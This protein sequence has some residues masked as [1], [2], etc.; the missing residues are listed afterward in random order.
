MSWDIFA[1]DVPHE[2]K[3]VEVVPLD[4]KPKS[5]GTRSAVIVKI[6]EV[7]PTAD[8]SDPSWG[9][10]D[11]DGW[12]IEVSMGEDGE[13]DGFTLHVRGSDG[14]VAAVTSILDGLRIRAIDAQTGEFFVAGPTAIESFQAWHAWRERA[15]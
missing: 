5:L 7:F 6:K 14:A 1:M 10:I 2:F 15:G 9:L 3:S 11:G 8:F 12:S 4:F 13:C